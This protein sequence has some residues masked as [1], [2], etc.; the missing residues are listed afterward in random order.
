[1]GYF[2]WC[3]H[4]G[5]G[6]RA[7]NC[8]SIESSSELYMYNSC[9]E[10]VHPLCACYDGPFSPG[11]VAGFSFL[12]LT[13]LCLLWPRLFLHLPLLLQKHVPY[14]WKELCLC[15]GNIPPPPPSP[16]H[17]S[18]GVEPQGNAFDLQPCFYLVPVGGGQAGNFPLETHPPRCIELPQGVELSWRATKA[19]QNLA[20]VGEKCMRP[21]SA[22]GV[23]G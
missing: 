20:H 15:H 2:T 21:S 12:P 14:I 7:S 17:P 9:C 5:C 4:G 18:L 16:T 19:L 22:W 8:I 10:E 23:G 3:W 11:N 6:K 1:M 13:S